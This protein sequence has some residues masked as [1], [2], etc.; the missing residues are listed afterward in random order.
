[1]S[2][3]RTEPL[4]TPAAAATQPV[5]EALVDLV[6][7]GTDALKEGELQAALAQFEKVIQAFPDR[8]EGHNNLGALYS[9]LGELDKAEICFSR[10]LEIL[11]D[12]PNIYYNRGVVRT[13]Q[14]KFGPAREDF[15]KVLSLTPAD[16]D[17]YNNLGVTAYL[18]GQLEES[19]QHFH[20]ALQIKS[21]HANALLNLCDVEAASQNIA[22]A[23]ELCDAFLQ[24]HENLLVRKKR[25]DLLSLDCRLALD[26]ASLAAESLLVQDQ[27]NQ[28]IRQELGRLLQAKTVLEAE[29]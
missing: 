23:L 29:A 21:D 15:H 4:P 24:R 6:K 9:S 12:N 2:A 3:P 20:Q 11:P 10:V 22:T 13:R 28:V 14:E 25:L 17:V 27:D 19:R 26:R 5:P 1:M 7:A 16:P 18:Q 8:P